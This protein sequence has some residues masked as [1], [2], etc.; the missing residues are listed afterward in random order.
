MPKELLKG[1]R[2]MTKY[3]FLWTNAGK[4]AKGYATISEQKNDNGKW[5]VEVFCTIDSRMHKIYGADKEHASLMG[6]GFVL[7]RYCDYSLKNID[8]TPFVI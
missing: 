7:E 8:E 2:I 3:E 6:R 5:F 4:E 1:G